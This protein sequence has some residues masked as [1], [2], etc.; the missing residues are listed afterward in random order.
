M[1]Q[2]PPRTFIVALSPTLIAFLL[3]TLI[4]APDKIS[5]VA[6]LLARPVP[7]VFVQGFGG[8]EG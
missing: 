3:S 2:F 6:L 1:A 5:T 7:T 8:A 4:V